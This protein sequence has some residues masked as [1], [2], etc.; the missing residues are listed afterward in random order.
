LPVVG[1]LLSRAIEAGDLMHASTARG[2]FDDDD[3]VFELKIDGYRSL[4]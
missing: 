2:P 3:C 1:P 4:T